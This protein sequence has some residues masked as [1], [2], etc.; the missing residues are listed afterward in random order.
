MTPVD[1]NIEIISQYS[2]EDLPNICIDKEGNF[3]KPDT[4]KMTR[5]EKIAAAISYWM[6]AQ[7]EKRF[8]QHTLNF[9]EKDGFKKYLAE[10]KPSEKIFIATN[11]ITALGKIEAS[12][13]TK[14]NQLEA[15]ANQKTN[16]FI[17]FF[18]SPSQKTIQEY[19]DLT[20]RIHTLISR[21]EVE[22][23]QAEVENLSPGH[24]AKILGFTQEIYNQL[25]SYEKASELDPETCQKY[26]TQEQK[27]AITNACNDHLKTIFSQTR[28]H[29]EEMVT[30][31]E[32]DACKY[33]VLQEKKDHLQKLSYHSY[34]KIIGF[35]QEILRNFTPNPREECRGIEKEFALEHATTSQKDTIKQACIESLKALFSDTTVDLQ[36]ENLVTPEDFQK[37][38]QECLKKRN[39]PI[40]EANLLAQETYKAVMQNIPD[41]KFKEDEP[42]LTDGQKKARFNQDVLIALIEKFGSQAHDFI[43]SKIV[44]DSYIQINHQ[45]NCPL[46]TKDLFLELY[47]TCRELSKTRKLEDCDLENV[48]AL[49]GTLNLPPL[50]ENIDKEEDIVEK[51]TSYFPSM[52]EALSTI[53]QGMKKTSETIENQ[54]STISFCAK[55]KASA[56][57]KTS[58]TPYLPKLY[59]SKKAGPTVALPEP[60]RLETTPPT[61]PADPNSYWSSQ[62]EWEEFVKKVNRENQ[63]W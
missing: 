42:R 11:L 21:L 26:A 59:S 51:S 20:T 3:N 15:K 1:R 56:L 34:A 60:A 16:P 50:P 6:G 5:Y 8:A 48:E 58:F 25:G 39:P 4:A 10:K 31:E 38:K 47:R 61:V 2:L 63:N 54:T 35:D 43:K 46:I 23:T 45:G 7:S 52:R 55:L 24:L 14:K 49:I 32:Y 36:S 30:K 18:F 28:V 40:Y 33:S 57:V 37:V 53:K 29:L 41:A 27:K 13:I 9:L 17:K 22:K 12:L 44:I 19:E 62:E